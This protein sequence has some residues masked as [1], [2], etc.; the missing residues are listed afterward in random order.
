[1]LNRGASFLLRLSAQ[2]YAGMSNEEI[3][4]RFGEI[5]YSAVSK[6]SARVKEEMA[7]DHALWRLVNA[8]D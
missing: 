4:K 2:R 6:A 3:G 1:M 5:H 8:L 7:S